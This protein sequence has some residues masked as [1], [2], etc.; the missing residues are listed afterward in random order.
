[1]E[2]P[3]LK[4]RKTI[5]FSYSRLIERGVFSKSTSINPLLMNL[6]PDCSMIY[7]RSVNTLTTL[8]SVYFLL[9]TNTN[10]FY[11]IPFYSSRNIPI[12]PERDCL[13]GRVVAIACRTRGLGFNSRAGLTPYYKG[14]ITQMVKSGCMLYSGITCT[15]AYPFGDKRRDVALLLKRLIPKGPQF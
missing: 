10:I 3:W 2:F 7:C 12:N 15:S 5:E 6:A 14:L 1:M 11:R 4:H 8:L 9:Q 13:V